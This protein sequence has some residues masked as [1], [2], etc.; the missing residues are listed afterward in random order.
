MT[1]GFLPDPYQLPM[2]SGGFIDASYL[3]TGCVGFG[4]ENPDVR[5][6]LQGTSMLL[7]I[8]FISNQAEDTALVVND[9]SGAWHCVDDSYQT[10]HPTLDFASPLEGRYDIWVTTYD[11]QQTHNGT[12]FITEL[13]S[14]HPIP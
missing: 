14:N 2:Y 9:P 1:A 4:G 7:R 3:G 5:I 8:Y 12:L 10:P 13:D 11:T 6:N